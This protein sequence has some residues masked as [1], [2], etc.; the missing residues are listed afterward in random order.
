LGKTLEF[1]MEINET[2]EPT[3]AIS[4]SSEPSN[5]ELG[6]IE[7]TSNPTTTSIHT[8]CAMRIAQ[9]ENRMAD[10]QAQV[11]REEETQ[12]TLRR[13]LCESS[14]EAVKNKVN[15]VHAQSQATSA[16]QQMVEWRHIAKGAIQQCLV[17]EV[18][19]M[20][21]VAEVAIEKPS[22]A[23]SSS[24][25]MAKGAHKQGET[26]KRTAEN[27]EYGSCIDDSSKKC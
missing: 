5:Q 19:V 22:T 15:L 4:A 26:R 21:K 23:D 3:K 14:D 6:P 13:M 10:L 9:L 16:R 2:N 1:I 25:S 18:A 20:R 27:E 12:E 17:E 7:I 11:V 8:Y 24:D